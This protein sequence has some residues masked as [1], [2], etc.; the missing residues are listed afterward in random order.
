MTRGALPG[1]KDG[2]RWGVRKSL[3]YVLCYEVQGLLLPIVFLLGDRLWTPKYSGG[4]K[5]RCAAQTHTPSLHSAG[6]RDLQLSQISLSSWPPF[7]LT[8]LVC[9]LVLTR[10]LYTGGAQGVTVS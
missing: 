4:S 1:G 3:P 7:I 6:P 5:F 2:T 8:A 9:V 10:A